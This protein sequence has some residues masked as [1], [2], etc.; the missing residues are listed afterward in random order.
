MFGFFYLIALAKYQPDLF[1]TKTKL[2]SPR[3][4]YDMASPHSSLF[5]Y[6][7]NRRILCPPPCACLLNIFNV[8][9]D[10]DADDEYAEI[11][12]NLFQNT[13]ILQMYVDMIFLLRA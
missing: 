7:T 6:R 3:K 10:F 5:C 2:A 1:K 13:V 8:L 11:F 4:T 12:M 9:S